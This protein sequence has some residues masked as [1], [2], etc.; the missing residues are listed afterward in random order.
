MRFV[1][2]FYS[3]V[4]LGIKVERLWDI[5]EFLSQMIFLAAAVGLLFQIPILMGI[6]L[7][8]N[9][10]K[11]NFLYLKRKYVYALL[12]ILAVLLPPT[13]PLSL[14]ILTTPLVFLFEIGLKF[15]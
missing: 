10:I 2:L 4:S 15:S 6:L 14:L 5:E 9:L 12:L 13:D 1:V 11:K 8:L 3:N 7:R